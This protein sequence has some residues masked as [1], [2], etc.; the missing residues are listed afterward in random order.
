MHEIESLDLGPGGVRAPEVQRARAEP[1]E[2]RHRAVGLRTAG[3]V[4]RTGADLTMLGVAEPRRPIDR[5]A[6]RLGQRAR[7]NAPTGE[8]A[9]PL[10]AARCGVAG[11]HR[12]AARVCLGR[13]AL[14]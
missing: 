12:G 7:I 6:V 10:R 5:C 9:A 11:E 8:R 1:P 4:P 2:V 3:I 14:G 13:S